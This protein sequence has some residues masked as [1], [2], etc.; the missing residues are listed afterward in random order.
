[1]AV[2]TIDVEN[3]TIIEKESGK[4]FRR[5]E[6][7]LNY[8]FEEFLQDL[9]MS[10]ESLMLEPDLYYEHHHCGEYVS[11]KFRHV[12]LCS[13]LTWISITIVDCILTI[14]IIRN[15]TNET[16]TETI[17]HVMACESDVVLL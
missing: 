2:I 13:K 5:V 7:D 16:V 15:K 6:D 12:L 10:F 3:G 1:M 14:S 9:K 8:S 4:I 17:T 11:K